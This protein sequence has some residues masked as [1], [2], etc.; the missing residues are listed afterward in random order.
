[1]VCSTHV[2]DVAFLQTTK[3]KDLSTHLLNPSSIIM[4]W[5]RPSGSV[6]DVSSKQTKKAALSII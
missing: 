2:P 3:A 4:S 5:M 1:M 6:G